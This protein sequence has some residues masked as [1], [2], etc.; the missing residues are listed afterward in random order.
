MASPLYQGLPAPLLSS[1][2]V[3]H[4]LTLHLTVYTT[5]VWVQVALHHNELQSVF[6]CYVVLAAFSLILGW[7]A[8]RL[9][10]NF[11]LIPLL[12]VVIAD[13]FRYLVCAVSMTVGTRSY[14]FENCKICMFLSVN[15]YI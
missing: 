15:N 12:L 6:I 7:L 3:Q 14:F 11:L 1:T 9:S 13:M 5:L 10:A 2:L 8:S 4:E